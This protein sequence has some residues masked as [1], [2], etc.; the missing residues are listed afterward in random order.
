MKVLEAKAPDISYWHIWWHLYHCISQSNL[1]KPYS[2]PIYDVLNMHSLRWQIKHID[3]VDNYGKINNT[4]ATPIVHIKNKENV[5]AFLFVFLKNII[6]YSLTFTCHCSR[7]SLMLEQLYINMNTCKPGT[8]YVF[9]FVDVNFRGFRGH[10]VIHENN[11]FV[12]P[13]KFLLGESTKIS[14]VQ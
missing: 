6:V 10:L 2:Y 8:V 3:N 14:A 4:N 11:F 9:I 13:Q 7:C 5:C 12:N 1:S